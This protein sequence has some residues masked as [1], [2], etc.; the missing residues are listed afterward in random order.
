MKAS[1]DERPAGAGVV[2]AIAALVMGLL[3]ALV[4]LTTQ[5]GCGT[6]PSPETW[7]TQIVN[8]V[9]SIWHVVDGQT[10]PPP[11]PPP[12]PPTN[13]PPP[14]P[15]AATTW[16]G[17]TAFLLPAQPGS[18]YHNAQGRSSTLT[19]IN[20]GDRTAMNAQR[21][22]VADY[23]HGIHATVCPMIVQN[24][25]GDKDD[26]C[27]PFKG[28]LG[29]E[30]NGDYQAWMWYADNDK[31]M[32]GAMLDARGIRPVPILFCSEIQN[33]PLSDPA[34]A[35]SYIQ[36]MAP[37]WTVHGKVQM[38]CIAMEAE[39]FMTPAV[40]NKMAAYV[41]KY[42]PAVKVICHATQTAYAPCNLDAIAVQAPWHPKDGDAHTPAEVSA[43]VGQYKQAG[44]KAVIVAEYNW[45]SEGATAKAQG[46][47]ALA[48]GAV[49]V[50][51]GW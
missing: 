46:Q 10:N 31:A 21:L 24:D 15:P 18:K 2:L 51:C 20:D 33:G 3:A 50:W 39:K 4:L 41:R 17:L 42:M 34:W 25:P 49:G 43:L 32:F 48:A 5:P 9:T 47:A 29:G 27:T 1:N 13:P 16:G 38:V 28:G 44:A 22:Y 26:Y 14:P 35:E 40:V 23:L 6:L 7:V 30:I 36:C 19:L 45:N 11:P 37:F 8:G 12:P